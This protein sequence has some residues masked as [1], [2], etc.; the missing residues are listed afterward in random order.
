MP[1]TKAT[2]PAKQTPQVTW[3]ESTLA[4]NAA[5][6]KDKERKVLVIATHHPPYTRGRTVFETATLDLKTMTVST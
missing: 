4:M 6:R 5:E 3:L 1:K 2:K